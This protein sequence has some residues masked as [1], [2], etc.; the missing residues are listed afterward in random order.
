MRLFSVSMILWLS[1]TALTPWLCAQLAGA[2]L[3]L[4]AMWRM[5]GKPRATAAVEFD[6]KTR[7]ERGT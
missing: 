2:Q 4:P 7:L 3:S 1:I 6:C 5:I